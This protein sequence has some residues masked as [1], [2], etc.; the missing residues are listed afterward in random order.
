MVAGRSG[1]RVRAV[2]DRYGFERRVFGLDDPEALVA[3]L[4]GVEV[5]LH[6]AGP[7]SRTSKPMIDACLAAR[8]HYL[9][10]QNNSK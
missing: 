4:A 2:A 7:F 8:A 10:L 1:E 9:D 5:L 6:C 3:A